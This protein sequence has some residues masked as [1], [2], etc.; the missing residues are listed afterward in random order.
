MTVIAA[1]LK[2][3]NNYYAEAMGVKIVN[4]SF[5]G[6]EYNTA[7]AEAME[8]SSMLFVCAAGNYARS[9]DILAPFPACYSFPN[10]LSVAAIDSTGAL[11]PISTYG[12]KIDIA[13]PGINIY[14][15][16]P[17]NQYGF[18]DG[19]SMAAAYASGAAALSASNN[20]GLNAAQM[21]QTIKDS[22]ATPVIMPEDTEETENLLDI[23][24]ALEYELPETE[25][26]DTPDTLPGETESEERQRK[27]PFYFKYQAGE[28]T[29]IFEHETAYENVSVSVWE[30]TEEKDDTYI[31]SEE[32]PP[33]ETS[34]AISGLENGTEYQLGAS[35]N[36]FTRLFSKFTSYFHE[37]KALNNNGYLRF[38]L[39]KI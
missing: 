4:C 5:A 38:F 23:T 39:M 27:Y 16:L 9:T 19:T 8:R 17:E 36:L 12:G 21:R 13:A 30:K 6:T 37:K 34:L 1:P 26:F 20:G 14:S 32:L 2:K 11:S 10:I 29:L 31:L 15:A 28:P 24:A 25:E 22:A 3:R 7:L 18:K 33:E 35:K